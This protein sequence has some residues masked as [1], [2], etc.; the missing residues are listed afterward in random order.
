MIYLFASLLVLAIV[1]YTWFFYQEEK[2]KEFRRNLKPGITV[3]V[4][5]PNGDISEA[6]ISKVFNSTILVKPIKNK[7][8]Q[9]T[10]HE[11][12]FHVP[13]EIYKTNVWPQS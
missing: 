12:E 3:S 1:A 13:V 6:K 2:L 9:K 10:L 7:L 4:I 8:N 5:L 11:Y